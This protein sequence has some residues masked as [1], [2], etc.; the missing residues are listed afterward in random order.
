MA[1]AA[2]FEI[3][4]R[5]IKWAIA[6]RF[7]C[8]LLYR[9][10]KACR[11]QEL[12]KPETFAKLQDDRRRHFVYW[13]ECYK[14]GNYDPILMKFDTQ[15]KKN[16]LGSKVR[17]AGMIDRFQDGR[18]RHVGTSM[19]LNYHRTRWKLVH[20]LSKICW[21]SAKVIKAEAYGKK[22]A[23]IKCKKRYRF[24]KATLYEREVIK[25]QKFCIRWQKLPYTHTTCG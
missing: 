2:I 22:T 18:R 21:S 15:T 10:R 11:V 9:L 19:L 17:K 12:Q 8:K 5:A 23:K 13:N 14:M 20:W 3:E 6:T 4:E 24:K 25:K 1:A 7:W 16:M